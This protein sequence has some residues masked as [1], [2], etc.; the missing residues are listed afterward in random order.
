MSS[1]KLREVRSGTDRTDELKENE[2]NVSL[3][4][5]LTSSK[6]VSTLLRYHY[7]S[8]GAHRSST[9]SFSWLTLGRDESSVVGV[10]IKSLGSVRLAKT[11]RSGAYI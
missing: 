8:G 10:L 11:L 2:R 1:Q 9:S 6:G 3:I 5:F 4:Y 7:T